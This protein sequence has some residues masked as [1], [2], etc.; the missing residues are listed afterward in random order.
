[1]NLTTLKKS[2][3][4]WLAPRRPGVD[5]DPW[6]GLCVGCQFGPIGSAIYLRS[7][8]DGVFLLALL[9]T[10]WSVLGVE[11]VYL[12]WIFG[13]GWTFGRIAE[14]KRWLRKQTHE[15]SEPEI[16]LPAPTASAT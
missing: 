11:S 6:V 7:L 16:V 9:I 14:T 13:G 2:F 5:R 4:S 15:P 3:L 1:M 12:A 8:A 10:M